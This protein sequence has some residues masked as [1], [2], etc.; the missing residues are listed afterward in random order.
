[1]P[2]DRLF[3][4]PRI[5]NSTLNEIVFRQER[6]AFSNLR[7]RR[8]GQVKVGRHIVINLGGACYGNGKP[9]AQAASGVYFGPWS[10]HNFSEELEDGPQTNQRA[11]INAAII[12]LDKVKELLDQEKLDT[13]LVLLVTDSQYVVDAMTQHIYKWQDNRWR[14]ARGQEVVNKE[15][16]EEL[17]E[18]IDELEDDYEV[19]V[20][21][22]WVPKEDNDDADEMARQAAGF[23]DDDDDTE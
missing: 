2:S 11:E 8:G 12:A 1:M 17:D 21:F 6:R 4:P 14:N 3:I 22:L 5:G 19:F 23:Y 20:K 7:V 13:S 10:R 15:D 9:W 16:F 18:L